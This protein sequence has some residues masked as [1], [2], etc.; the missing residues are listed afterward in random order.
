MK[1]SQFN[2]ISRD[3]FFEIFKRRTKTEVQEVRDFHATKV[4]E[5]LHDLS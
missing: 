3:G 5:Y 2:N 1:K 4:Y